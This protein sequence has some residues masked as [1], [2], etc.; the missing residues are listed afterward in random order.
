M[1]INVGVN[2]S[3]R[4]VGVPVPCKLVILSRSGKQYYCYHYHKHHYWE[5]RGLAPFSQTRRSVQ[6]ASLVTFSIT[7]CFLFSFAV[8]L[9]LC[10]LISNYS[11]FLNIVLLL[12]G[13]SSPPR[14]KYFQN[15]DNSQEYKIKLALFSLPLRV[16]LSLSL[17]TN[18]MINIADSVQTEYCTTFPLS[19][20]AFVTG[21]TSHISHIYKGINAML[22]IRGPIKPYIF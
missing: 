21:L 19:V 4:V 16:S 3:L 9:L 6:G 7:K 18:V 17:C 1:L 2:Q 22:I 8:H 13:S 14:K 15:I 12:L 5:F 20:R 11:S 10:R